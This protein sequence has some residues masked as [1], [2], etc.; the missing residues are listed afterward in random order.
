MPG[1]AKVIGALRVVERLRG[2]CR[3]LVGP[4]DFSARIITRGIHLLQFYPIIGNDRPNGSQSRA[5]SI[6]RKAF[7]KAHRPLNHR[8]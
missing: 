1:G 7:G 4:L 8:F 3:C 5:L 2:V 6:L